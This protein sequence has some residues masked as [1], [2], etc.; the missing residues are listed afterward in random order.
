[1]QTG[2]LHQGTV[3]CGPRGA[4]R[5]EGLY[6]CESVSVAG[7][8]GDKVGASEGEWWSLRGAAGVVGQTSD[9]E[10]RGVSWMGATAPAYVCF[11][12]AS[13]ASRLVLI[14]AS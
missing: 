11:S 8:S 9:E 12:S 6:C 14:S 3:G 5:E 7:I 13:P 1:M 10:S 2:F 4:L